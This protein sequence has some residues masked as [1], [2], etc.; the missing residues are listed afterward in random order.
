MKFFLFLVFELVKLFTCCFFETH[1]S[2]IA[3]STAFSSDGSYFAFLTKNTLSIMNANSSQME[4][5]LHIN[6]GTFDNA[7]ISFQYPYGII[8]QNSSFFA[9]QVENNNQSKTHYFDVPAINSI[10]FIGNETC[11]IFFSFSEE[12]GI[13]SFSDLFQFFPTKNAF[14]VARAKISNTPFELISYETNSFLFFPYR[15]KLKRI[16]SQN[17]TANIIE[18]IQNI[19]E[20]ISPDFQNE[21]DFDIDQ[22]FILMSFK[23]EVWITSLQTNKTLN[24]TEITLN[25]SFISQTSCKILKSDNSVLYYMISNENNASFYVYPNPIPDYSNN[26]LWL[27]FSSSTKDEIFED[28]AIKHSNQNNSEGEIYLTVRNQTDNTLFIWKYELCYTPKSEEC[29][30]RC[31]FNIFCSDPCEIHEN[32]GNDDDHGITQYVI[33]GVMVLLVISACACCYFVFQFCFPNFTNCKRDKIQKLRKIISLYRSEDT[34]MTTNI[35]SKSDNVC[36]ICLGDLAIKPYSKFPCG[37]HEAHN[38]CISLYVAYNLENENSS[39]KR[40]PYRDA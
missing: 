20:N 30:I 36:P 10:F 17:S 37:R 34:C 2:H 12:V 11:M 25:E 15:N 4:L 35:D 33:I 9:F 14:F 31:L 38:D 26:S 7:L 13:L 29:I 8:F 23:N 27:S 6:S 5:K 18:L 24:F 32:D 39:R 19:S 3:N 21:I 1:N 28:I 22:N 40:C 16:L